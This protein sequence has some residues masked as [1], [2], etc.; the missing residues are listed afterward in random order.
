MNYRPLSFSGQYSKYTV[1]EMALLGYGNNIY[2]GGTYGNSIYGDNGF[3]PS[4]YLYQLPPLGYIPG[5][6]P[7]W[8]SPLDNFDYLSPGVVF[9]GP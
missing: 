3:P 7:I 8:R 4:N 2:Q 5:S 6:P 9:V 1:G